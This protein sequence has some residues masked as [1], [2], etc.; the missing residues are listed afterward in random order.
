MLKAQIPRKL[1]WKDIA[2]SEIK[3]YKNNPKK[4]TPEQ[5][6][7][8]AKLLTDYGWTQPICVDKNM[9]LIFGHCRLEAA[10]QLKED[11]VPVVFRE[12]LTPAQ[13][14]ALRIADNKS[15]ES[16]WDNDLR[17]NQ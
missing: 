6:D 12:D 8:V 17:F 9:T 5:I 7:F 2:I 13:V 4:H 10:K 16:A 1:D 11:T 14:K 15:N 3:P